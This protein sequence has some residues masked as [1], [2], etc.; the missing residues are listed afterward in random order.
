M[1]SMWKIHGLLSGKLISMRRIVLIFF[2]ILVIYVYISG[3]VNEN[4]QASN[5]LPDPEE[6]V[7]NFI[8]AMNQTNGTKYYYLIS[9]KYRANFSDFPNS[10][11]KGPKIINYSIFN[12]KIE[13]DKATVFVQF[14]FEKP[15]P[16]LAPPIEYW[17]APKPK[18][19]FALKEN[20][21]KS[22]TQYGVFN[23]TLFFIL[24]DN[25]W[26][27]DRD[28]LPDPEEG[29]KNFIDAINQKN[30]A[31]LIDLQS[32]EIKANLSIV[33]IP[34]SYFE[35][36]KI[37]NYSIIDK[38][39]KGD[40]ATCEVQFLYENLPYLNFTPTTQFSVTNVTMN[41]VFEDNQWRLDKP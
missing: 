9:Q 24:E 35:G 37:V 4:S 39:I 31:K 34:D 25:Q 6:G 13:G 30:A 10:T 15:N 18:Y 23:I 38:K 29:V 22:T 32:E 20:K 33:D 21:F 7:K 16:Y 1:C 26:K 40:K 27:L 28:Q 2:I 36:L 5:K 12:K 14:V 3:C 19:V 8:D 17:T 11:F 41:F